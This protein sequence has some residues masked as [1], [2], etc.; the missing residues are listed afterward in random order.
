VLLAG[1]GVAAKF[2][3]TLEAALLAPGARPG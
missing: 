1:V 2:I 3:D